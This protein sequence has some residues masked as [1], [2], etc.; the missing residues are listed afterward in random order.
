MNG[1]FQPMKKM[2]GSQGLRWRAL[3]IIACFLVLGGYASYEATANPGGVIGVSKTGCGGGGCHA[4]SASAATT[5]TI[6]TQATQIV[7]GQTYSFSITIANA[8][9]NAGGCDIS[10]QKGKLALSTDLGLQLA[11]KELTQRGARSFASGSCSFTFKYTAPATAGTDNIFAAGNAVNGN[12]QNDLNDH[13]NLT[14]YPITVVAAGPT[15]TLSVPTSLAFGSTPVGTPVTKTLTIQNTGT[16]SLTINKYRLTGT[17]DFRFMDTATHTVANGSS[18]N[19]TI[20]YTPSAAGNET[21]TLTIL[22]NDPANLSKT[23]SLNGS[24]T[25]AGAGK[26]TFDMKQASFDTVNVSQSKTLPMLLENTG[27]A[28]IVIDGLAVSGT[29]FAI[30]PMPSLPL[31]IPAMSSTTINVTF[32]PLVVGALNASLY[33][34]VSEQTGKAHDTT[35]LLTGWSAPQAGVGSAAG[36]S[37]ALRLMPNPAMTATSLVISSDEPRNASLQIVGTDGKTVM[38][39][40]LGMLGSGSTTV[41]LELNGLPNGE[42]FVECF[43]EGGKALT[44]KLA[45]Q[46]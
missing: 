41:P 25:S 17:S 45:I 40:D 22:S 36:A 44:A 19:I 6:A 43:V 32:A 11:N 24:G 23:V 2:L 27:T 13:W 20:Q 26:L 39:R 30:D 34:H 38:S 14:T 42:Y 46:R 4:Q 31:T 33:M 15:P 16:A 3:S 29:G 8:S 12:G 5:V 28:P 35:F 1:L 9:E 7:A 10:V 37:L 18:G 21:A